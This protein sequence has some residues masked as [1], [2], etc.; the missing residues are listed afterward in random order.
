ME[1]VSNGE[2]YKKAK[3]VYDGLKKQEDD[4]K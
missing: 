4:A 1:T 3:A 2:G